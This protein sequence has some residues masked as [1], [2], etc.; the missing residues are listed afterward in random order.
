VLGVD[1]FTRTDL[2]AA[3]ATLGMLCVLLFGAVGRAGVQGSASACLDNHRVLAGAWVAYANDHDGQLANNLGLTEI[4]ATVSARTYLNWANNV[5]DW[6]MTGMNTNMAMM[7]SGPLAPYLRTNALVFHCPA[8]TYVS[9]PQR[10]AGWLRRA[11]SYS[12]NAFM[13]LNSR[14]N[15]PA[16]S[17]GRNSY[18]PNFRQFLRLS[19]I[20][21]PGATYVFLDEH[22]DSINDGM[23][24]NDPSRPTSWTDMPASFHDGA[25]GFGFAD[26]HA[27][28]H[29]W[30][31]ASTKVPVRFIFSPPVIPS[32][33]SGDYK[34]VAARTS[35]DPTTLGL[36]RNAPGKGQV[37]WSSLPVNYVLQVTPSLTPATWTDVSPA[38]TRGMGQCATA[39][40]LNAERGFYRLIRR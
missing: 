6:T 36:S 7:A 25:C 23:F 27:E 26:G 15:D 8:D 18:V 14:L 40:D 28:M 17:T 3:A 13:G 5:M 2:L 29:V 16:I 39:V 22:P 38:P 19:S 1:A 21:K 31:F 33:Q 10:A 37:T 20:P 34:W 35:V 9:S 11:R 30:Q 32:A 24:L 4:M 12:M